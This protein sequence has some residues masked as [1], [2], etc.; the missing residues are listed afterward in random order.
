M[1]EHKQ[2]WMHA[3]SRIW[4]TNELRMAGF[5]LESEKERTKGKKENKPYVFTQAK[6]QTKDDIQKERDQTKIQTRKWWW[7]K[8]SMQSSRS[9]HDENPICHADLRS[10]TGYESFRRPSAPR[11]TEERGIQD[12][13]MR[14]ITAR[15]LFL[16]TWRHG[17][18]SVYS[19]FTYGFG[20]RF[21]ARQNILLL[22]EGEKGEKHREINSENK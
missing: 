4:F 11:A 5:L 18:T 6:Y 22:S 19:T 17:S 1:L 12:T 21:G 8:K 16:W 10:F 9:A 3:G 20:H 7:S 15:L 14:N 13:A 2:I